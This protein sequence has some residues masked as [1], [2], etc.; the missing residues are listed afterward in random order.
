M[1]FFFLTTLAVL[2]MLGSAEAAT[3]CK[4]DDGSTYKCEPNHPTSGISTFEVDT[5]SGSNPQGLVVH[6]ANGDFAFAE[7]WPFSY[8]YIRR[9]FVNGKWKDYRFRFYDDGTFDYY[10]HIDGESGWT[11]QF[12]GIYLKYIKS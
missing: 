8:D 10:T 7:D 5:D 3:Q 1:K 6:A 11:Y 9:A 2:L 4:L 12:S